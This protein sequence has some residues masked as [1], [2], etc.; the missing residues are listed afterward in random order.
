MNLEAATQS[1]DRGSG[2]VDSGPGSNTVVLHL[3]NFLGSTSSTAER[4]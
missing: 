3:L 1:E 4:R 2:E